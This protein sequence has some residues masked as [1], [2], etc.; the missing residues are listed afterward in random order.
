MNLLSTLN[1]LK[2]KNISFY[3]PLIIIFSSLKING[4]VVSFIVLFLYLLFNLKK[5]FKILNFESFD[6]KLVFFYF[7]YIIISS[8]NGAFQ[9]NDLR[10]LIYW[11]PFCIV[12]LFL[13][14]RNLY[15]LNNS[16]FY[17][18]N[19]Y[20]IIFLVSNLY[21]FLYLLFNLASYFFYKNPFEIQDLFWMGSSGAF[22]ISSLLF[23]SLYKLWSKENFN[24]KSKFIFTIPFYLLVQSINDS[25][26]G[27]LYFFC[28]IF[29]IFIK[30][31]SFK[32]FAN[33]I[34]ILIISISIYATLSNSISYINH[35]LLNSQKNHE[36][37]SG[38]EFK[39]KGIKSEVSDLIR[40][41]GRFF[42]FKVGTNHFKKSSITHKLF[43][44]GWYSSRIT[45]VPERDK[46]IDN[47]NKLSWKDRVEKYQKGEIKDPP[48]M[49][50]K[51]EVVSMQG[52]VALIIDTG[53]FGLTLFSLIIFRTFSLII[54]NESDLISKLFTCSILSIHLLCLY[55]GYPLVSIPFLLFLL[56]NGLILNKNY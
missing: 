19:Y 23:L 9:I 7:I 5:N 8:L 50:Y 34:I 43:G 20:K 31:L 21:F 24:F 6:D 37:Y 39:R 48:I 32:K 25:R 22:N 54:K 49:F 45:I 17:R 4:Y 30:Q 3:L 55:L 28:F 26:L 56:P 36:F 52:I 2:V 51:S 13:Y 10:I 35:L 12:C 41:D 29:F 53:I 46:A 11:I 40:Y 18:M 15:D 42:E 27:I 1:I 14:F 47:L 16:N 33:N 38:E 44:S